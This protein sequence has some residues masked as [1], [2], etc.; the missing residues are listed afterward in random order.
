MSWEAVGLGAS[1]GSSLLNTAMQFKNYQYQKNLQKKMFA[2]EDTSIQRRVADLR[3]AGLSPVLAAGQGASAGPVVSTQAPQTD[4][5]NDVMNMITMQENIHNSQQQRELSKSQITQQKDQIDLNRYQK[6]LLSQQARKAEAEAD[7]A[8]HEANFFLKSPWIKGM[9]NIGKSAA[10]VDSFMKWLQE[11]IGDRNNQ[12][13]PP[14]QKVPKTPTP[15]GKQFG[16][17]TG[18]R[19]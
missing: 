19:G 4:L 14:N 3:A 10:E 9:S 16:G 5:A 7:Y 18:V 12:V 17:S 15:K 8:R 2:R 6:S 11:R 13:V 1:V